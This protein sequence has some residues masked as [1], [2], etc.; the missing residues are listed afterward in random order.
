MCVCRKPRRASDTYMTGA[1]WAPPA[2]TARLPYIFFF[3]QPPYIRTGILERESKKM[4]RNKRHGEMYRERYGT[5]TKEMK[6]KMKKNKKTRS[7]MT[8]GWMWGLFF[9]PPMIVTLTS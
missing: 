7:K 6:T 1:A 3:Y 4:E 8:W 2:M 5:E 9:V